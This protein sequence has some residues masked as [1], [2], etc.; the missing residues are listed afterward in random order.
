LTEPFPSGGGRA[1]LPVAPFWQLQ[2]DDNKKPF[3]IVIA[4]VFK[5]FFVWKYIK[6]IFFFILFLTLANQNDL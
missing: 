2:V 6:I 4:V 3:G 1:F 5:V